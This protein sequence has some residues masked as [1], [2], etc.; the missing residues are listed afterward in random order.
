MNYPFLASSV[1]RQAN[2][3]HDS[4]LLDTKGRESRGG[5]KDPRLFF[6]YEAYWSNDTEAMDVIRNA[7]ARG[8][9]NVGCRVENVRDSLERC[10]FAKHND[11]KGRID[12][13]TKDI[14]S[15]V[16]G[17]NMTQSAEKLCLACKE[18]ADIYNAE[19]TY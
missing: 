3:N 17:Q 7:W 13:L 9:R 18:L 11:R 10:Q 12:A 1:I 14:N 8:N 2:S 16:D 19:E 6:K 4:V 15:I 5:R